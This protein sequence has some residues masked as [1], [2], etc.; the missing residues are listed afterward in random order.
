[1][2]IYHRGLLFW[3]FPNYFRMNPAHCF[4]QYLPSAI[5]TPQVLQQSINHQPQ[6]PILHL[7]PNGFFESKMHFNP[8]VE[9]SVL[10]PQVIGPN[11]FV[12][13][14]PAYEMLQSRAYQPAG[15]PDFCF[16]NSQYE[17]HI[18]PLNKCFPGKS[19]YMGP[20]PLMQINLPPNLSFDSAKLST[21]CHSKEKLVGKCSNNPEHQTHSMML[22]NDSVE[23]IL[24]DNEPSEDKYLDS[25]IIQMDTKL[26][27]ELPQNPSTDLEQRT[28]DL[29]RGT[30]PNVI[31]TSLLSAGDKIC[32]DRCKSAR[33]RRQTPAQGKSFRFESTNDC[34]NHLTL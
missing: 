9:H 6:S 18:P 32:R 21:S 16:P 10:H 5:I 25:I 1:M 26:R 14:C 27:L 29:L 17:P 30:F 34:E 15:S 20:I 4:M 24:P 8:Q 23:V 19:S 13:H 12:P 2:N 22:E 3:L 31:F 33:M 7:D 28:V 11:H